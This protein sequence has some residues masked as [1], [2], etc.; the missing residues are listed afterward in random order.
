MEVENGTAAV[1]VAAVAAGVG[2]FAPLTLPLSQP[3]ASEGF[4]SGSP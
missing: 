2:S 4:A 1:V 3:F